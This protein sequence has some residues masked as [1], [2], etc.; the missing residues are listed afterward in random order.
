[1]LIQG[2]S[3]S[4]LKLDNLAFIIN[5]NFD[6][7]LID[8]LLKK[9]SRNG[10]NYLNVGIHTLLSVWEK[11]Q[12]NSGLV[13]KQKPENGIEISGRLLLCSVIPIGR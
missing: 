9:Y 1:M 11:R 10:K 12:T 2:Q 4:R 6:N 8:T 13:Y 5:A 3:C 7:K